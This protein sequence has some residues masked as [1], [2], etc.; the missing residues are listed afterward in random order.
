MSSQAFVDALIRED[1]CAFL[2]RVFQTVSPGDTFQANWH[3]QAIAWQLERIEFGLNRRLVINI[4]PRSLKTIIASIAWPAW[5]LGHDPTRKIVCI[6]YSADLA[7]SFARECRKVMQTAWFQR[8]FPACRLSRRTAEHDFETTRGGGRFSTSIDGTLTGRGGHVVIIDDPMKVSDANSESARRKAMEFYSQTAI[9][10]LNDPST[11]AMLLVMQRLHEDDL[12]G[13]LLDEEKWHHL[14]LPARADERC[15]IPTGP[16]TYHIMRPGE[17]LEPIRSGADELID[18]ERRMGSPTFS[19][20]YLQRPVP[21][22]GQLIRREWL[23]FQDVMP[24]RSMGGTLVQSWD[25][26]N[27]AGLFSDYSSCVTALV[28][29]NRIYV[30]DVYRERLD[31]PQ[32]RASV[33]RLANHWRADVLLIEDRASGE[34]LLRTLWH[35]RPR[36]VPTPIARPATTDKESRVAGQSHRIEAGDLILPRDAPWLASFLHELLG[37]PNARYDDQVDALTHLL[38]WCSSRPACTLNVGPELIDLEDYRAN[39]DPNYDPI[40]ATIDA[41]SA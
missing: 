21:A 23:R 38:G 14:C 34:Q 10:R 9:S 27:K 22:T 3:H 25:T 11:G 4:P 19:A 18:L 37:F 1:F 40:Q 7:L 12:A 30:L 2:Q 41:W 6:S 33:V 35:D 39:R 24:D 26:A 13:R 36:G 17:Y 31:F 15:K 28:Q 8:A 32:L 16:K 5:L 20:Q 29:G